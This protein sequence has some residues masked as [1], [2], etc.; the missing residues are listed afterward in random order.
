[1]TDQFDEVFGATPQHG[2]MSPVARLSRDLRKAAETLSDHEARFLVDAYYQMQEQR[3]R[4]DGQIRSIVKSN[5][6]QE[7]A[8]PHDV[9]T[10]LSDQS[11]ALEVQVRGALDRYV[12]THMMGDW[13]Y[14]V[15]GIGPVI[16]AGIL[17]HI[18]INKAPTAGHIM[19]YAG[20]V[21]GRTW[22]KGQKR[23]W[24]AGLK[25][26]FYKVGESFVKF[27]NRPECKYGKLWRERKEHEIERNVSGEL[28]DQATRAL[29]AKNFGTAT[30]ARAWYG[31]CFTAEHGREIF[32]ADAA[33]RL[34]LFAKHKGAPG[35]G[36]PMLPP[37]H[38]HARARRWAVKIFISNL[39]EVWFELATGRKAP[40]PYA[41][42]HLNHAHKIEP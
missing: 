11:G 13:L 33:T 26:L 10:W 40:V 39:H 9:L 27:S 31:G 12:K 29:A 1:M 15:Y 7:K 24:N 22:E 6:Q 32:A 30:D 17:A 35:S 41:M 21:E 5:K 2:G 42:A 37:A 18:D 3:I 20:L 14:S 38:I 23:P 28:A 25:T 19:S 36:L 34:E 8:E 16:S 4:A